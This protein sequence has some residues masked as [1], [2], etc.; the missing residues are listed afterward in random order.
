MFGVIVIFCC[1]V[2]FFV[3]DGCYCSCIGKVYC[4]K[5]KILVVQL[6]KLRFKESYICYCLF[7]VEYSNDEMVYQDKQC[8]KLLKE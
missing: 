4:D 1:F 2:I 6:N 8:V 3:V 5:V 7:Q